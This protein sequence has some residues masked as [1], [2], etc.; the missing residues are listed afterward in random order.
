MTVASDPPSSPASWGAITSGAP[1]SNVPGSLVTLDQGPHVGVPGVLLAQVV[2]AATAWTSPFLMRS[3]T[4]VGSA[5]RPF[6]RCQPSGVSESSGIRHA[7]GPQMPS[8]F[9]PRTRAMFNPGLPSL[10]ISSMVQVEKSTAAPK[11]SL[12]QPTV[13]RQVPV[14]SPLPPPNTSSGLKS[15]NLAEST[16][17]S[18][19]VPATHVCPLGQVLTN[20]GGVTSGTR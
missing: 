4:A 8:V 20:C 14:P 10:A 13:S 15:G 3:H 16:V 19:H 7:S 12:K 6:C 18:A 1:A 11:P 2:V 17:S 5:I 9:G